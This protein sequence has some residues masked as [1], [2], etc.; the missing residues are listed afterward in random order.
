MFDYV[1]SQLAFDSHRDFDGN[2]FAQSATIVDAESCDF[3]AIDAAFEHGPG[4][5]ELE[6]AWR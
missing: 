3:A 1:A 2:D 5:N 6:I 4:E